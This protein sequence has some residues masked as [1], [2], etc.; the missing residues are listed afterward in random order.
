MEGPAPDNFLTLLLRPA[1]SSQVRLEAGRHQFRVSD[2]VH[3]I[4][5]GVFLHLTS[6]KIIR[7][8]CEGRDGT[9]HEPAENA[10]VA[11]FSPPLPRYRPIKGGTDTRT[12]DITV[13]LDAAATV[14]YALSF[15]VERYYNAGVTCVCLPW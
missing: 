1:P 13:D 7:L 12:I 2:T 15:S 14:T 10:A 5:H 9:L 6:G 8:T 3:E 11:V 4:F